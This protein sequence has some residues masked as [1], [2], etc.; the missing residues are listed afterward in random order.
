MKKIYVFPVLILAIFLSS[1]ASVKV[2]SDQEAGTD[3][4]PYKTFTFLGWQDDSDKIMNEFDR[5]RMRDA[6]TAEFAK[7]DLQMVSEGADMTVSLYLV[8]S[9]E[10]STTAY[11]NYY[12]GYGGRYGR[13][14]GGWGG[15]SASTTY[16]E[17]DY[18]KGTLVMDVF[19]EKSGQQIWQGIATGT[20]NEKPAKREK[21]IPY[22][23]SALMKKFPIDPVEGK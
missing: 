1:C 7:R 19:D 6:F 5:K 4:S 17:S 2:T 11:T 23:V 21:S 15:G 22:A 10:T 18:L 3:F 16:T 8:V 12:G 13:Y 20:V 9:K 14:G